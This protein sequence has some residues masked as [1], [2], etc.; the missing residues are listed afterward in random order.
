MSVK[1][2]VMYPY[3]KDQ[4]AFEKAYTT[5]HIPMVAKNLTRCTKAVYTRVLMSPQGASPFCRIAELHYP[6]LEALQADFSTPEAQALGAHAASISTGG[7]AVS[8]ICDED[9]VSFKP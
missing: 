1:L 7:P 2:V 3:P 6:S 9:T 4:A 8:L 5:E